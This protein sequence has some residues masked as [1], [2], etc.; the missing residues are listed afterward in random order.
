[1]LP[2]VLDDQRPGYVEPNNRYSL[3]ISLASKAR[4]KASSVEKRAR[5][6]RS[7]AMEFAIMTL[8]PSRSTISWLLSSIRRE[9]SMR[10][11]PRPHLA[12]DEGHQHIPAPEKN[13]SSGAMLE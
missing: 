11:R 3:P 7:K 8:R 13:R 4:S 2:G 1:M 9:I 5:G 10:K 12:L 6:K